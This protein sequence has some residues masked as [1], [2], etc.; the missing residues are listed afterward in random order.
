M[1]IDFEEVHGILI[2]TVTWTL[3]HVWAIKTNNGEL[4]RK[5]VCVIADTCTEEVVF[6]ELRHESVKTTVLN[7]KTPM[8]PNG[9]V[10]TLAG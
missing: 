6:S 7:E 2:E 1:I 3:S 5:K 4:E 9:S 8:L 10:E